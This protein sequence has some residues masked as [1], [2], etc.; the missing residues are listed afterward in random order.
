MQIVFHIGAHLTDEDRLPKVLLKNRVALAEDGIVIPWPRQYRY[1]FRDLLGRLD[2]Q[3]ASAETED[4]IL[5]AVMEQDEPR[6]V[7]FCHDDFLSVRARA[8]GEGRLYP[9]AG[10]RLAALR[11]IFPERPV[12]FALALRNP[13]TLIPA[14][15]PGADADTLDAALGGADPR[16]LRWSETLARVR[17]AVPDCPITVWCNEDAPVLWPE[18]LRAVTGHSEETRLAHTDE[19]LAELIMPE[20]LER[21]RAYM[22][23]HP[24]ATE[25]RRRRAVAAFLEKFGRPEALEVEL[26]LPGWTADLVDEMS[27]AYDADMAQVSAIP[28]VRVLG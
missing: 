20:G 19:F 10:Q 1:L 22:N 24:P 14:L 12:S 18:V 16:A 28:G 2:G 6:R 13:A 25:A 17:D 23:D 11:N 7:V 3:K 9:D 4:L 15:L 26:D 21:M 27:S 8:L 5:D